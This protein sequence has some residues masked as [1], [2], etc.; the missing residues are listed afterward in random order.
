MRWP[1]IETVY[2]PFLRK[3]G[4]SRQTTGGKT[5]THESLNM[6]VRYCT[7]PLPRLTSFRRTSAPFLPACCHH[8][9]LLFHSH[10]RYHHARRHCAP[11]LRKL[12]LSCYPSWHSNSFKNLTHLWLGA[13]APT[14]PLFLS[15]TDLSPSMQSPSASRKRSIRS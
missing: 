12:A 2:G 10:H 1:S 14:N 11:K 9:P 5:C 4:V 13:D 3:A 6:Y 15:L 7:T 8:P